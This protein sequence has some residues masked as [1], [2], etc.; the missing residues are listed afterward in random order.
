MCGSVFKENKA[1][2]PVLDVIVNYLP[3]PDDRQLTEDSLLTNKLILRFP[4]NSEP[5]S[6]L[7]FEIMSDIYSG[8]LCFVRIYSGN[9]KQGEVVY[10]VRTNSEQETTK[11]LEI[12]ANFR[13]ELTHTNSG[14][15]ISVCGV[16]NSITGDTLCDIILPISPLLLNLQHPLPMLHLT[17]YRTQSRKINSPTKNMDNVVT[18]LTPKMINSY[19]LLLNNHNSTRIQIVSHHSWS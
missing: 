1:I 17:K 7:I 8:F 9:V 14:D 6:M 4:S 19:Q 2:Q 13:T 10:N 18:M 16:K 5:T 11:L 15:I 3:S 12:R